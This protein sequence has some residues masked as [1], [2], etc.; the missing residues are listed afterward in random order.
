MPDA[1]SLT[2][3]FA[4]VLAGCG[5]AAPASPAAVATTPAA[6]QGTVVLTASGA[7]AR[8][9]R[10]GGV[11]LRAPSADRTTALVDGNT[12][13]TFAVS[14]R[15]V[16]GSEATVRV[17]GSLR[18][19]RRG[20]AVRFTSLRVVVRGR[21]LR[22]SGRWP[23]GRRRTVL[24]GAVSAR[25]LRLDDDLGAVAL[26]ATTLSLTRSTTRLVRERLQL[27]RSPRGTFGRLVVA[28]GRQGDAHGA[29]TAAGDGA[30]S[31]PAVQPAE[32]APATT[33][34]PASAAAIAAATLVWRV[35]ESFIRYVN[36]GE[37]ATVR[38]GAVA[39]PP[40]TLPEAGV[41][42]VYQFR[43]PFAAGWADAARGTASVS[44]GGG[45][46]FRYSAHGI[47]FVAS[48]P[49][50]ELDGAAPRVTFVVEGRR[51]VLL[52][53]HPAAAVRTVSPDGRTVTLA[54]IPATVPAGTSDSIFAGFYLAGDPFG[55]L[56]LTTTTS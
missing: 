43:F 3:P 50:V 28:A 35:R 18:L 27:R 1:R 13:M 12:R 24:T 17:R 52:D 6:T 2:I 37:G 21:K 53:L 16:R 19:S 25:K 45:V 10:R 56:T 40:E 22:V 33:A 5:L 41:P 11:A 48:D 55:W 20:R 36:T 44:F 42:L 39:D 4:A 38:D 29:P 23:D 49:I 15:A 7:A 32:P 9:L 30:A 46:R 54:Q 34:R 14:K 8:A 31:T 26:R 51:V 47:D